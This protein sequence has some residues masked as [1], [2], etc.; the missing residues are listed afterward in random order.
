MERGRSV[1]LTLRLEWQRRAEEL[2]VLSPP[3][4]AGIH[5]RSVKGARP[6]EFHVRFNTK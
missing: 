1:P 6:V 3:V 5:S 2:F 4:G